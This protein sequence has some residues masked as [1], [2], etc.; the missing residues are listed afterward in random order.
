MIN[1][2]GT[3]DQKQW[4]RIIPDFYGPNGW[5]LVEGRRPDF[6]RAVANPGT[7]PGEVEVDW[8]G[9]GIWKSIVYRCSADTPTCTEIFRRGFNG[10][11]DC[12]KT[13]MVDRGQPS[14]QQLVYE[15]HIINPVGRTIR[16]IS[17]V[18]R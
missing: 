4:K 11:C 1:G 9:T 7:R 18:P 8:A 15:I 14:G 6:D 13:S 5:N 16:R 3:A 17:G 2:E 10:R 12:I